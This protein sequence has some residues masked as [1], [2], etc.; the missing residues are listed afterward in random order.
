MM[1][2]VVRQCHRVLK[3]TGSALF[4][5]Q[6]NGREVG[7]MRAWLWDFMAWAARNYG[8]VQDCYWW[9]FTA[10]PTTHCMRKYGLARPNLSPIERCSRRSS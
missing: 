1:R 7:K 4:V 3:P 5:L 6:A 2:L 10:V 9:N 8:I